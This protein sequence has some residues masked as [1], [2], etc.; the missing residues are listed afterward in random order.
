M[1]STGEVMGTS[2]R[3]S[4][5]FAKSQLAA[6]FVFPPLG[7]IFLSVH[8][9]HKEVAEGLAKRLIA[10]GYQLIATTGTAKRLEE[11][12]ITVER[13]N[14]IAEGKPNVLDHLSDREIVLVMNTPKGKGARTD[15]GRIRA[16]AIQCGVPCIT[17][18]QAAEATVVAMEA[19][20]EEGMSVQSLQDRL[21]PVG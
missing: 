14:K 2:E 17:T 12:G 21:A 6:G 11:A 3:F 19:I 8:D 4:I 16:A 10:L 1:R 20:R 18:I 15:E 5:A 7:K 13:V 9:R